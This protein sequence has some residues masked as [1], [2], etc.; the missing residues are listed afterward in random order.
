MATEDVL[1]IGIAIVVGLIALAI[2]W[3]LFKT[4]LL[5]AVILF[6]WAMESGFLGVAAYVACWV[7]LL[8]VMLA[9]SLIV[10]LVMM[11]SLK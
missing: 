9:A 3:V 2:A 5:G 4:L 1:F 7:F 8:P 10:G 11:Y 6:G